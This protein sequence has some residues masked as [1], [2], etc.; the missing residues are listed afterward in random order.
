MNNGPALDLF[1]RTLERN[2]TYPNIEIVVVDDGSTDASLDVLRRW[3][4]PAASRR[5][6][7]SSAST[8]GSSTP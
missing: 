3:R 2:T 5:S 6:R 1:F 7:S 4:A 8:A